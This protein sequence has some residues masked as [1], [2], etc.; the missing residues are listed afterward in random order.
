MKLVLVTSNRFGIAS[1]CLVALRESERSEVQ[2]V[3]LCHRARAGLLQ[4]LWK[5]MKKIGQVGIVGS[6]IGIYMRRFF[7][8]HPTEEI[9]D[10]CKRLDVPFFASPGTNSDETAQLL[11]RFMPDVALSLGNGYIAQ[12]IF[13]LP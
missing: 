1:D 8:K 9:E 6:L 7:E 4:S 5:K 3:I 12:K 2:C 10:L 13:S 11:R